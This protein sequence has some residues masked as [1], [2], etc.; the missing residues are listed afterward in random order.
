MH[1][2]HIEIRNWR[3]FARTEARLARRIFV[4]GPN[5]A[6]KSNLLDLFRFLGDLA[7]DGLLR[8][9]ERRGGISTL[10]CLAARSV[11]DISVSVVIADEDDR[12]RW[13]YHVA[14]NLD[15]ASHRPRVK[16]ERVTQY[17]DEAEVTLLDRPDEHDEQDPLRLSQTA[18]EQIIA[19]RAFR[20]IADFFK[21]IAYLHL[22]PQ[23]VRDPRGF[24]AMPVDRDPFGRDFLQQVWSTP[25]QV[26][27]ARLRLIGDVLRQ[28]VPQLQSLEVEQDARDG[29]PHLIGTY[30]HW[31][32]NAARHNESLFS[33]GTLRLVGL[34]WALLDGDGPLL[35][36]EPELS[37]HAEIVRRIPDLIERLRRLAARRWRRKIPP[38]QMII[39]THSPELTSDGGIA[40]EEVLELE[41]S[42]EGSR[43][44]VPDEADRQLLMAGLPVSE[45]ILPRTR[46]V[47]FDQLELTLAR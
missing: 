43:I 33:D 22:I 20:E 23:V 38:R 1:F 21:S 42:S 14:L 13:R 26:R 12:P 24:S 40:A 28:A 5:A 15:P 29:S 2:S 6:G 9:V 10:R 35:L 41:P 8:S 30:E 4:L 32:P 34:L 27:D 11:S 39:S 18:L 25:K 46:P 17:V 47:G 37:L 36:E 44:R 45:V 19:N 16:Q 3:N 7:R 31:R